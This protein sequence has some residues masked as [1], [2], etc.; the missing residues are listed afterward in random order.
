[1]DSV[2]ALRLSKAVKSA[3]PG[4]DF[5][6]HGWSILKQLH[7]QGFDVYVRQDF[8]TNKSFHDESLNEMCRLAPTNTKTAPGGNGSGS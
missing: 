1:M 6:D 7:A 2:Y 5:I 3:E 4:G 8:K